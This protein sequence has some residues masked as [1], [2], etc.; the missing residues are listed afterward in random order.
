[1]VYPEIRPASA[2]AAASRP[3]YPARRQTAVAINRIT[4][5]P[6]EAA[7]GR[8][9]GVHGPAVAGQFY[10][11]DARE[12]AATVDAL[13]AAAAPAA[14]AA[15]VEAVIAPHAGYTYSGPVAACAFAA[16][17]ADPRPVARV[18]VIGPSHRFAFS[19]LALPAA[20]ALAIPGARL[21]IDRAAAAALIGQGLA[22]VEPRA[23]AREH[24][25]EVELPFIHRLLGE[26]AI[27]PL[28]VGDARAETVV[29]ALEL[30]WT[31]SDTR[32]V[33]SSD[34]SHFLPYDAAQQTDRETAGLIESGAA[35][36]IR[37]ITPERACGARALA[38]FLPLA[39]RRGL[40]ARRLDLRN[41]FDTAGRVAAER[42]A[43]VGYGAWAFGA[44]G[45]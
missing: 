34:L 12:L 6:T 16:W 32:V 19:G 8:L 7:A 2:P 28:V 3:F 43:V 31:S 42:R 13:L 14:P 4:T 41:S 40:R 11:A 10:P 30:V 15:R 36:S 35:A 1:M 24:A 21:P 25:L 39:A 9:R 38:G 33:V 18:V 45:A 27:V 44:A 5:P 26:V 29:R 37:A 20:E 23:H 17:R 22:I